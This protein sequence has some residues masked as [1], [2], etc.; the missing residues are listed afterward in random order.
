[1]VT[2]FTFFFF[3]LSMINEYNCF[4]KVQHSSEG[5]GGYYH[6][7]F[8]FSLSP[9][10]QKR[11]E[12]RHLGHLKYIRCSH[13]NEK[14]GVGGKV[15]RWRWQV[16]RGLLQPDKIKSFILINLLIVWSYNLLFILEGHFLLL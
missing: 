16:G 9:Q 11:S 13:F 14:K 3:F 2:I 7:K 1:M 4:Q 5:G 8:F 15:S 6:L 10:N 12:L